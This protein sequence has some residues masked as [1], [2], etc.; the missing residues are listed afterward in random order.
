METQKSPG[1]LKAIGEILTSLALYLHIF[2]NCS[3]L[4]VFAASFHFLY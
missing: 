1:K 3:K 4:L 2:K